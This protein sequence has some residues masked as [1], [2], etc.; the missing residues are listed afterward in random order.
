VK[1]SQ[2]IDNFPEKAED[3]DGLEGMLLVLL[4]KHIKANTLSWGR[5]RNFA[6][7]EPTRAAQQKGLEES[8]WADL[9]RC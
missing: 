4:L 8:C 2:L 7:V 1:T 6:R 3:I 9:V 5:H